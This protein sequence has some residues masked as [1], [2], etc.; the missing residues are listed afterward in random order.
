MQ[1]G[2]SP[3]LVISEGDPV[4]LPAPDPAIHGRVTDA[5][6]APLASR[7]ILLHRVKSAEA[8]D[9]GAQPQ[10][11]VSEP[12]ETATD[13]QGRFRFVAPAEG[14]YRAEFFPRAERE[15]SVFYGGEQWTSRSG[16]AELIQFAGENISSI[17]FEIDANVCSRA[18]TGNIVRAGSASPTE[19]KLAIF[20][21]DPPELLRVHPVEREDGSFHAY[22]P[23]T[24]AYRLRMEIGQRCLRVVRGTELTDDGEFWNIDQAR[25]FQISDADINF[26]INVKAGVCAGTLSVRILNSEGAPL[27]SATVYA[28]TTSAP[29]LTFDGERLTDSDGSWATTLSSGEY[30]LWFNTPDNCGLFASDGAATPSYGEAAL[31]RVEGNDIHRSIRIPDDYCKHAI[32]GIITH[33]NGEP[34][35]SFR[36]SVTP[37]TVSD[38]FTPATTGEDGLYKVVVPR[39]ATYDII[40]SWPDRPCFATV[41]GDGSIVAPLPPGTGQFNVVDGDIR[42]DIRI[43]A[44]TCEYSVSGT[45][46][47]ED[48]SVAGL[49]GILTLGGL[50]STTGEAGSA[51]GSSIAE[52]G[53]FTVWT[54][55]TGTYRLPIWFD[56]V[57]LTGGP[58]RPCL[59][60]VSAG[61]LTDD[62]RQARTFTIGPEGGPQDIRIRIPAETADICPN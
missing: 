37:T 13:E 24:G 6:G 52:D 25:V 31:I 49:S 62:Q 30:R 27:S 28:N 33:A 60:F 20:S 29:Y 61:G 16:A 1:S 23:E 46:M 9:E 43:P 3:T 47:R 8:T 59:T 14:R 56:L 50:V 40:L 17:D 22:V 54:S 39:S 41:N 32:S 58:L 42:R 34:A 4:T 18:I 19:M 51:G 38:G 44:G 55:Q 26:D 5:E 57:N 15:C 10:P 12:L 53:S 21:G 35:Q 36:V 11:S 2:T 45:M 48:G 7:R